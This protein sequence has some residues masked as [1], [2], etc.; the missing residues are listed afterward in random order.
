MSAEA[1]PAGDGA[2]GA[3][4]LSM[5][6]RVL[7]LGVTY[8]GHETRFHNLRTNT[9]RDPRIRPSYCSVV[10]WKAGGW[11]ERLPFMPGGAKGRL[12]ALASAGAMAQVPRPDVIWT[13]AA[14][15]TAPYA[16]SQCGPLRRPVVM[17]LDWTLEQQ[18][19]LAPVYFRRPSKAGW[20]RSLAELQERLVWRS[21]SLFVP[22]SAWAADGLR[23]RGI[24]E[25]R[26]RIVPPGVDLDQWRPAGTKRRDGPLRVL[27]VGGD[28]RRK[29]GEILVDVIR[30]H[31]AGR[32]ELDIVTRDPVEAAPGIRV[33][34]AEPN[35]PL[36][37]ELYSRAELFA[38]P[39][40]AECFGIAIVEAMA[41][42][43]PVIAGRVGGTPDIVA[44]G[45]TGWLIEPEAG[46]L[47]F[48]IEHAL[49]DRARL[50]LMGQRARERA[51]RRFDGKR[52]DALLVD[53]LIEQA[54]SYRSRGARL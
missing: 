43:L 28:F 38:M 21:V 30:S 29:G 48:A 9:E 45:E 34:R 52:N 35:S 31:F 2:A 13:S 53:L 46:M 7:F 44:D 40:Q 12:R 10:G 5:R 25:E 17:D 42:G 23:R 3:R 54:T 37:R 32:C 8:A 26:V 6:P 4:M 27:F 18:E 49:R 20:R 24:P 36:L 11:I 51:E 41:S 39:T 33:H 22:W 47:C 14:E 50:P 19:S 1:A 15:L 16:W